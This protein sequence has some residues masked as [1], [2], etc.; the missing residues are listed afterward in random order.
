[1]QQM[2]Y[3][4]F[5]ICFRPPVIFLLSC[6]ENPKKRKHE[7]MASLRVLAFHILGEEAKI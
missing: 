7:K 5:F 6:L 3:D 2:E 4:S 1:M